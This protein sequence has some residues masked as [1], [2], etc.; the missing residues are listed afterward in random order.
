ASTP[1]SAGVT[2]GAASEVLV[3]PYNDLDAA[4]E[5]AGRAGA[6]LAAIVVEPVAGN[7]GLVEPAPG[8]LAGLRTIADAAGALLVF[9]EVITGFRFHWGGYQDI[10][11]VRPDLTTL[12]KIIGGGLPIGAFGGRADVMARLAPDGDVYQA[13]TLS[14]NPVA[15]AA[16][17]ATLRVLERDRPYDRM[18]AV[19]A[20]IADAIA[21]AG[22][23]AGVPLAVPRLGSVLTPFFRPSAPSNLREAKE[24]DAARYGAFFRAMA[25]RG[26]YLP[27]ATLELA[28]VSA[29][30]GDE[31]VELISSR[32]S[33][34]GSQQAGC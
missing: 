30:H 29:A 20:R 7:M 22:R 33:A 15:A 19:A 12:G 23:A 9:D 17:L 31:E 28:F 16:G 27:P 21:A 14:G 2:P 5:A 32:Q 4:R 3:A 10:C 11:G 26:V 6:D 1:A 24:A 13:G 18:T 8:F 25:D 34:V